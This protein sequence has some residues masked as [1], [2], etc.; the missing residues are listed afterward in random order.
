MSTQVPTA[1]VFEGGGMRGT[2]TAALVAEMIDAGI[3][4]PWV[5]GISAGATHTFNFV[6]RDS[7]RAR[8]AFV[9]L[10]RDPNI[11]GPLSF[12]RGKG[13]FNSDYIYHHT[14]G[15]GQLLPFDWPAFEASPVEYKIGAFNCEEGRTVYWGREDATDHEGLLRRCQASSSIPIAMPIVEIDGVAYLDGAIGATGGFAI[16]AAEADG[17]ERFVVVLTRERGYEKPQSKLPLA[18]YRRVFRKYP[19]VADAILARADN[20]NRSRER[21][22]ALQ[23]EGRAFLYYPE[24]VPVDNGERDPIK[25]QAAYEEGLQQ[26]RRDLP[27]IVEFLQG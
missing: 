12:V 22:E 24:T 6:A 9:D 2:Y 10:A 5:G 19:A 25:I 23:A 8:A 11:G 17:Y 18:F 27:K 1:L 21:L 16:D 7:W 3:E 15:P 14:S 4:F 26:A 13:Y 20:Y